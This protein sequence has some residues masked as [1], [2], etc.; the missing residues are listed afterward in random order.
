MCASITSRFQQLNTPPVVVYTYD[1]AEKWC[2]SIGG[3]TQQ[4]LPHCSSPN[5]SLCITVEGGFPLILCLNRQTFCP[6]HQRL[7]VAEWWVSSASHS[8]VR[9]RRWRLVADLEPIPSF[10]IST[11]GSELGHGRCW[12]FSNG[13]DRS[14]KNGF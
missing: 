1:P 7:Q 5:P 8:M 11:S 13:C 2:E 6:R 10:L 9:S 4:A 14:N 3:F 12:N